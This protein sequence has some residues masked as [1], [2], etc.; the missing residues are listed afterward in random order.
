MYYLANDIEDA[1]IRVD[2]TSNTAYCKRI[3]D[4]QEYEVAIDGEMVLGSF[5]YLNITYNITKE[6][7]EQF[8]ITWKFGC[9]TGEIVPISWDKYISTFSVEEPAIIVDISSINVD[10]SPIKAETT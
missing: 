4:L 1:V 7:Y 9:E 5:D 3:D 6:E 2:K 10:I 8:G